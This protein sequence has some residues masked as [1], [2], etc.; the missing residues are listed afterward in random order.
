MSRGSS[1]DDYDLLP[2]DQMADPVRVMTSS[3]DEDEEGMNSSYVIAIVLTVLACAVALGCYCCCKYIKR[4]HDDIYSRAPREKGSGSKK[5]TKGG[6]DTDYERQ[7]TSAPSNY[8]NT[9]GM[10][11]VTN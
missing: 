1:L 9:P 3:G 7:Q 2:D 4:T 11:R 10:R 6:A 5:K 8:N